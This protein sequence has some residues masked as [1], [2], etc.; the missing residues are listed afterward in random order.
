MHPMVDLRQKL[1][2]QLC[3]I[4]TS[5]RAYDEGKYHESLRIAVALRVLLHDPQQK[6]R[7]GEASLLTHMGKKA[8]IKL[9]T[10]ARQVDPEQLKGFDFCTFIP[11]T[12]GKIISYDADPHTPA[13]YVSCEDWWNQTVLLNDKQHLTRGDIVCAA[14]NQDGGA[15]VDTMLKPKTIAMKLAF[16]KKTNNR[17]EATG[18]EDNH[19]PLLRQFA[20]EILSSP[21]LVALTV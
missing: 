11:M 4:R 9:L 12:I 5:C 13:K 16:W 3:F 17:G 6:G 21:E 19:Y 1:S 2:N 18:V 8:N 14:A 15:H 20:N 7:S 10:T